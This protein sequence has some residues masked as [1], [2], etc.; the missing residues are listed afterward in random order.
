VDG[1]FRHLINIGSAF[2]LGLVSGRIE[3]VP[4]LSFKK[5]SRCA[6]FQQEKDGQSFVRH[7]LLVVLIALAFWLAIMYANFGSALSGWNKISA[8]LGDIV[9]CSSASSNTENQP[10]RHP[11]GFSRQ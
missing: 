8:C 1:T 4:L 7:T 2:A 3:P 10:N 9:S 5:T 11:Y 6:E